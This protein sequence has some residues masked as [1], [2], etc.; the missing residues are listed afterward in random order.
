M[1]SYDKKYLFLQ[2]YFCLLF[3]K[4]NGKADSNNTIHHLKKQLQNENQKKRF[5]GI[6][7][8]PCYFHIRPND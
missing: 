4:E 6:F 8:I 2:C 7:S 1:R 3:G 5:L